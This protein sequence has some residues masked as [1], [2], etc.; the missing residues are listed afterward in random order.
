MKMNRCG[1]LYFVLPVLMTAIVATSGTSL[2]KVNDSSKSTVSE[3]VRLGYM[4]DLCMRENFTMLNDAAAVSSVTRIA[5]KLNHNANRDKPVLKVQ[6][7]NDDIPIVA[8]FPGGYLYVSSGLLD[9][10]GN[11]N[12]LAAILAV[13]MAH[14]DVNLEYKT[15][16]A[17][18]GSRKTV[19]FVSAL[20]M[21]GTAI[22]GSFAQLHG[23]NAAFQSGA[24]SGGISGGIAAQNAYLLHTS[25]IIS[26]AAGGEFVAGQNISKRM[27]ENAVPLNRTA[28]YLTWGA[29]PDELG[30]YSVL[31]VMAKELYGGYDAEEELKAIK[32]AIG[33][34]R[35]AGY[36][37]QNIVSVLTKLAA[38]QN[39][40]ASKGY[41]TSIWS[42]KPGITKRM[43][44]AKKELQ[45]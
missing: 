42:A 12:E 44:Y 33:R 36:E 35:A 39:N 4:I 26:S 41:V 13:S 21:M 19:M 1:L 14:W 9:I 37:P 11:E 18:L 38:I 10:L 8:S 7:L 32:G 24:Q 3:D 34:L 43:D 20:A 29:L 17:D 25:T 45:N 6:V 40:Y 16:T 30:G 23:A 5:E 31:T 27:P 22:G 15:F 2:A 28:P